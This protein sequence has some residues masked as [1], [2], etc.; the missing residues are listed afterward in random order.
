MY[1]FFSMLSDEALEASSFLGTAKLLLRSSSNRLGYD[2]RVS[3]DSRNVRRGDAY[4]DGQVVTAS[5][6]G[7]LANVSERSTHDD[8]VVTVLLVVVEDG[9]DGLDTRVLLLGVVLLRRG[10]VPV[11]DTADEGGDQESTG[12]SGGDGLGEREHK[13][14]V[15]VDAVVPLQD[16]GGLD[17]LPC[18]GNLN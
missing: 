4:G 3:P 2:Y 13:S 8:G 5:E 9:L 12:L 14:Q 7:D 1:D 10:L 15:A 16:L 11:E 17:T 18:R 6:L